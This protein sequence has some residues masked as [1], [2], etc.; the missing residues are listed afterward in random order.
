MGGLGRTE[1]QFCADCKNNEKP[2]V[3]KRFRDL[4]V[5]QGRPGAVLGGLGA[6][7]GAMSNKDQ[8]DQYLNS[9]LNETT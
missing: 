2:L 8:E 3:F 9:V 6:V 5:S 7:L 4:G 1:E